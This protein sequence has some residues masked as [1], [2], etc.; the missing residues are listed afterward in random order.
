MEHLGNREELKKNIFS[1]SKFS[2]CRILKTEAY[3]R[4]READFKIAVCQGLVRKVCMY[5]RFVCN[6]ENALMHF[7]QVHFF[8]VI[9]FKTVSLL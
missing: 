5:T 4:R 3:F 8:R 7:L 1:E 6:A 2:R 9:D